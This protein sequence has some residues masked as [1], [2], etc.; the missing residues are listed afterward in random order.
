ML[1]RYQVFGARHDGLTFELRGEGGVDV[2]SHTTLRCLAIKP[3]FPT[4]E[5]AQ[6]LIDLDCGWVSIAVQSWPMPYL[7]RTKITILGVPIN[8]V[9]QAGSNDSRM[10]AHGCQAAGPELQC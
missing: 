8:V 6:H 5:I 10:Q 2:C 1:V 7:E 9:A 4:L 3:F